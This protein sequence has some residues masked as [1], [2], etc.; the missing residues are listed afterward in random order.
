MSA[1]ELEP[2]ERSVRRGFVAVGPRVVHYRRAGKGTVLVAIHESPRSS[3]TVLPL[4][5]GL[6]G[7]FDVIAPD[8]P[9]FGLSDPL[10][11]D[12][13]RLD[14]LVAALSDTL[15]ALGVGRHVLYGTHTGAAI[16]IR[17]A[18]RYPQRVTALVLDG[19]AL[20]TPAERDEFLTRYLRHWEPSWDGAHIMELWSRS[21]DMRMWFPWQR[22]EAGTRLPADLENADLVFET[23]LGYL[24]AGPDY[25]R[26]YACAA[27]LV[28]ED[29]DQLRVP[30]SI[31]ARPEDVLRKHGARLSRGEFVRTVEIDAGD[32]AWLEAVREAARPAG[33]PLR[34]EPISADRRAWLAIGGGFLHVRSY[35]R[36]EDALVILDDVPSSGEDFDGTIPKLFGDRRVIVIDLPGSGGSDPLAVPSAA[37]MVHCVSAACDLLRIERYTLIALGATAVL[38]PLF[39]N[40]ARCVNALAVGA[41][42][43]TRGERAPVTPPLPVNWRPDHSGAAFLGSWFT[44]RDM[45]FYEEVTADRHAIR[46]TNPVT[47]AEVAHR[48][49]V[50]YWQGRH[51]AQTLRALHEAS[52]TSSA[53]TVE[54]YDTLNQYAHD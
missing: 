53:I 5:E 46:K 40:E 25:W 3:R 8:T 22:R 29:L 52:A 44:L 45:G 48:G 2:T 49:F 42:T 43:W 31:F 28:N 41:P 24:S 39:K 16:A 11:M 9:G 50:R 27:E 47:A 17:F 35:G 37:A 36:G 15:D 19:V 33:E 6:A 51:T 10:T 26:G 21:K 7:E 20:F 18:Q 30:T 34:S 12:P 13:V 38:T 4:L 14:D 32:A 54:S 23:V 1:F